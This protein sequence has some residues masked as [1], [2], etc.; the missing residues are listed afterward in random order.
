MPGASAPELVNP[1]GDDKPKPGAQARMQGG[2]AGGHH[3]RPH[4]PSSHGRA[5]A[6]EQHAA[7]ATWCTL[8]AG[9]L[10]SINILNAVLN[11]LQTKNSSKHGGGFTIG[12]LPLSRKAL[13]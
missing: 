5:S 1:R 10:F 6:R 13:S 8:Q 2:Q 3:H 7:S 4:R 9:V 12:F 11:I